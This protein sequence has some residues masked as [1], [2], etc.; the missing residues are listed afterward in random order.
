MSWFISTHP[1]IFRQKSVLELGAGAGLAGF[2]ASQIGRE[3]IITDGNEV[4]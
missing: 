1:D 4:L 3:T 2:V